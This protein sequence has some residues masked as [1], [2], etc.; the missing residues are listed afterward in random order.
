[1]DEN[2]V[3]VTETLNVGGMMRNRCLA[4]AIA[5]A[6]W[7]ELRRQIAYKAQW[8]QRTHVEVDRWFPS[9][10]R[11]SACHA[12]RE[13]LTLADRHWR[14]GACGA[15]HDRDI[16]AAR[17]LEQEGCGC[18]QDNGRRG[19]VGQCAWRVI[20]LDRPRLDPGVVRYPMKRERTPR[21]R[22]SMEP[23][24]PREGPTPRLFRPCLH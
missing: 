2:P 23:H 4:R 14:C 10:R 5:D 3:L 13:G 15:E 7:G 8:A 24:K 1:M 18:S 6:G 9:T 11:C 16:N 20:P 19:P 12:V 21:G 22:G 17:N